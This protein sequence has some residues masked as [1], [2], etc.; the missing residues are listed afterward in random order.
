MEHGARSLEPGVWG[1]LA[2]VLKSGDR[3]KNCFYILKSKIVILK[4]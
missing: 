2:L 4:S 3:K 1:K